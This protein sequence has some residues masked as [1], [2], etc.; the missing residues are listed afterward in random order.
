M[1]V[2]GRFVK[3]AVEQENAQQ[4]QQSQSMTNTNHTKTDPSSGGSSSSSSSRTSSPL[5]SAPP[6]GPLAPVQED[7]RVDGDGDVEMPDVN[8]P[9]A[10]FKPT[11]N[12]PYRRTRRH[13]IT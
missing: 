11:L 12:Q 4:Q 13:T 6:S 5:P 8:D 10:G 1:R 9:E 7:D 2:K 3:R